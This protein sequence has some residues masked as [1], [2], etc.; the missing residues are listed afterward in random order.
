MIAVNNTGKP[1]VMK[2]EDLPANWQ[3]EHVDVIAPSPL[4]RTDDEIE[5][6][7]SNPLNSLPLTDLCSANT[8]VVIVCDEAPQL[9]TRR[10][11]LQRLLAQLE[12]AA[13]DPAGITVL[14]AAPTDDASATA[15]PPIVELEGYGH[16]IAVVQ[17]DPTDRQEL[18]DLGSYEGVPLTINYRAVEADLLIAIRVIQPEADGVCTGSCATITLGVGGTATRRELCTTR[19][20]DDRV[21]PSAGDRPLFV[22]VVRE[23]ARRAGLVFAV[24]ALEDA[25][26][27]ALAVRAGAPISVDD[28]IAELAAS[29]REASVSLPAYDIVFAEVGPC[30]PAGVD[31]FD[32]CRAAINISLAPQSV[33]LR[34]GPLILSVDRVE[35]EAAPAH[36]F[37]DALTNVPSPELVIRQLTGRS[38]SVGEERAYLLAHAMQRHRIVVAGPQRDSLVRNSH[39]LSSPTLREAAELAENFV[40]KHPRALVVHH[41]LSTLP[42]YHGYFM[43]NVPGAPNAPDVRSVHDEEPIESPRWN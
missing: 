18:D 42:V 25:T 3:V 39:F 27:R 4:A 23:G 32:A 11:I 5:A 38:L 20:Y 24:A 2:I 14:I 17:H 16:R 36:A 21:E 43:R 37:Y 7:L 15:S 41:A 9:G 10:S 26:G 40:G 8:R 34:G 12:Q 1:Y 28:A 31:L 33:L 13:V 22:R 30:P 35:D 29:L 6:Q 19:F